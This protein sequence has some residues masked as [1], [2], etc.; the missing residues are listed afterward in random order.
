MKETEEKQTTVPEAD[1]QAE[2]EFDL[3]VPEAGAQADKVP[4]AEATESSADTAGSSVEGTPPAD[5]PDGEIGPGTMEPST[6]NSDL[7]G[8][9]EA[10]AG[11][12]V[13]AGGTGVPVSRLLVLPPGVRSLLLV[14]LPALVL[15]LLLFYLLS[16]GPSRPVAEE[17]KVDRTPPAIM[18]TRDNRYFVE[19]G[20][21]YEEEGYAAYDNLDGDLTKKVEVSIVGDVVRYKVSDNAGNVTV[22]FRRIPYADSR[23]EED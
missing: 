6:G 10:P 3:P 9:G 23:A 15:A 4:E 2:K 14:L 20:E 13:S 17:E 1:A 8:A 7:E 18:L 11:S 16:G 19:P 12:A 5:V 21:Q 22:R